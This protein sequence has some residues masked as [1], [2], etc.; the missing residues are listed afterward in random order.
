MSKK[1]E[2][3]ERRELVIGT[4]T[5]VNPYSVFI[6]LEEYGNKEG[7]V[8]ISEVAGKWVRDIRDFVKVGKKV[9]AMVM[10]VDLEKQH[11]A[12]SLKRVRTYDAEE[13]MREYK[14][15]IKAEKMIEVVA[16]KLNMS[17]AEAHEKIGSKLEDIFGELFK[18]FQMSLNP[19]GYELLLKKGMP[20]EWASVVKKVADEQMEL[21]EMEIKGVIEL[22]N[23][24]PDGIEILKKVLKEAK[25]KYRIDIKYV[26]APKYSLSIK[27]KDAKLGEKTLKEA[28]EDMI[29]NIRSMGG[30]GSFKVE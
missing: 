16:K 10:N 8:H 7:M 1:G 2:W 14:R 23:Y 27:T 6:S 12:L 13:K 21:K 9:V 22:K 17:P 15:G 19:Q 11:I 4:V 28:S 25:E 3:P 20:E 18:A 29:K 30:E 26:S 24:R 5:R